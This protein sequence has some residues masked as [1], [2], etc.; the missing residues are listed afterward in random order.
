MHVGTWTCN[1]HLSMWT[2]DIHVGIWTCDMHVGMWT[3]DM[4][5]GMWTYDMHMHTHGHIQ[6]NIIRNTDTQRQTRE[7]KMH[8]ID[9][10]VLCIIT[11]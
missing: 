5:V 6:I 4:H 8:I 9:L 3:Y 7:R 1:M 2:C 10:M 11:H